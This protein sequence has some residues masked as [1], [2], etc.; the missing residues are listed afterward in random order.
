MRKHARSRRQA[1]I[2]LVLVMISVAM[3]VILS[4]SF[5]NAQVTASGVSENVARRARAQAV[6]E[7]GLDLALAY[8]NTTTDWRSQRASGTWVTDYAIAGGR[9]T[10]IGQDG[11]D[12]DGDQVVEGDANFANDLTEPVTLTS[13]GTFDGVT[14]VV[15]AVVTPV[16]PPKKLLMV[17][18]DPMNLVDYERDPRDQ[19]LDWDYV[20]TLIAASASQDAIDSAVANNDVAYVTAYFNSPDLNTKLYN[21]PI[22]VVSG[23][24]YLDSEFGLATSDGVIYTGSTDIN[25]VDQSHFITET[26]PIG[27]VQIVDSTSS[28]L[29]AMSGS[30]A[31]GAALLATQST[32]AT[33]VLAVIEVGGTLADTTPAAGRRVGVPWGGAYFS[34]SELTS[35][36]LTILRRSLEW[37]SEPAIGG[38]IAHWKLDE[39][40]GTTAGDSVG[41]F[42]GIFRNGVG[43]GQSGA[44]VGSAAVG[45]DGANDHI[46][47]GHHDTFLLDQGTFAFWFKTN[48]V[49]SS[50]GLI[51]KDSNGL[52]TGGHLS[53]YVDGGNQIEVRL[54]STDAS[55]FV[56]S[57]ADS[58]S[59]DT[60]YH[61]AFTF[62]ASGMKL[63]LNGSLVAVNSYTGGMG[64]TS[65]G[66][67]NYEPMALGVL[68]MESG[69]LTLSGWNMPLS[70][71]MDE[72]YAFN[73][74]LTSTQIQ[75]LA[76]A[77]AASG[78]VSYDVRWTDQP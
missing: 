35:A 40:T 42:D 63:Y 69:D 23:E 38:Q 54:Q 6:A 70:G 46:E 56:E 78:G 53:I 7:S 51:S 52:D 77:A 74:A 62:G 26:L 30:P 33:P 9:V 59:A 71:V 27:L 13:M 43:L 73:L 24:G 48:D 58:V 67:G 18:Q 21:A 15:H 47:I 5:L 68:T 32:S 14:H 28:E 22:G 61:V 50:Q 11:Q 16:P 76:A 39:V 17:V 72:V 75:Q 49:V 41:G 60:W 1:G 12:T 45:Y 3:A 8:M 2:A 65:G 31:A 57:A 4:L 66:V 55:Y 19:F 64:T 29:M 36:G 37:A 20:V 44:V 10:V 34:S 25:V